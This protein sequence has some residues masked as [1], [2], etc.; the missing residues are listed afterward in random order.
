MRTLSLA[1][2]LARVHSMTSPA[3]C[4]LGPLEVNVHTSER[5]SQAG[6]KGGLFW[7]LMNLLERT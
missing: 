2:H 7:P 6:I 5:P 1:L 4:V 3:L